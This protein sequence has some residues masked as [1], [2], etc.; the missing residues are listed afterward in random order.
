MKQPSS[1]LLK[2]ARLIDI[3]QNIDEIKDVL[4]QQGE[5]T[6]IDT[7]IPD[8]P[9]TPTMDLKGKWIVPGLLDMHVHLREP[10]E[11]Y[12]ETIATGTMAAAAGGFT[13]VACMPNTTPVNDTS[14]ITRFIIEKS[15][16]EGHSRVYPVAS[17]T[18]GQKGENLT[19]FG[20]LKSAGAIALS[21]DG[22]PVKNAQLMR[23][24]LEYALSF[25]MLIISH[26]EEMELSSEGCMNEGRISTMLGLKG[27]P[28]AAEEVA[29]YRDIR[30]A[31]FTG[32]RLHIAHVSTKESVNAIR[33]AKKQGIHVTCET[34]P[35]YFSLTEEA[36]I[37][38][39]TLAKMNPPL[40]TEED[41]QAI[42]QGLQDGTIDAIATD[43]APHSVLEKE[44]EFAVAANG[45][46]GLETALPLTLNL[47]RDGILSPK[48]MV[49]LM[50]YSPAKI[51]GLRPR[52]LKENSMADLTVI[53]PDTEFTVT[54]QT[55][56][57][58]A[59]NTPFLG[60]KLRGRALLTIC[61][62]TIT[63]DISD[64]N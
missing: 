20:D 21:D 4:I 30:L 57:S 10:G 61:D 16:A 51:L 13:A 37:G 39:N 40:R 24:A 2:G 25:D 58:K 54:P 50:S 26:A 14:A 29:I 45:I 36:V 44:L 15:L 22:Y 31:A 52:E 60:Q 27:I 55:L 1:I 41:R 49:R 23:I 8:H 35:H 9:D 47:V 5:I 3:S 48:D 62:G 32:A 7:N 19:E 11:E 28:R 46:I 12:K 59:H 34:A 17:I 18:K 42:I 43:H 33:E 38:Y 6:A 53:D 56:A 63:H 64:K